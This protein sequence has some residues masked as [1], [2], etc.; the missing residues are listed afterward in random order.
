MSRPS[1]ADQ[2]GQITYNIQS[3]QGSGG[4]ANLG[5]YRSTNFGA[6]Y[7]YYFAPHSLFNLDAFFR[8]VNQ[9][10]VYK[11]VFTNVIVPQGTLDYCN[12]PVQSTNGGVPACPGLTNP[13]NILLTTPYNGSKAKVEGISA[14]FQSD[15]KFGFGIQTNATFLAQQYG[16]F[17]TPETVM[18]TGSTGALAPVTKLN[19]S[20]K[21]PLPYLSKWSYTIAPYYEM[22]KLEVHTSYAWRSSYNIVAGNENVP[23][24]YVGSFGQMDGSLNY[25]FTKGIELN[26]SAVNILDPLVKPFTT[27]GLPLGYSK[28]GRRVSI[29]L[30]ARLN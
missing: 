2:S 29:G 13:V 24:T 6:S 18:G 27:G 20:N 1:F 9:Y 21:Y 28:Y 19:V 8:D 5:P 30:T 14:A 15:L 17:T 16:S 4:N 23:A 22:G 7:E 10:T 11:S 3:R 12:V 26:V 25:H